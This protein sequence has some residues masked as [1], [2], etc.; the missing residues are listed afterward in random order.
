MNSS[1]NYVRRVHLGST[2]SG[3]VGVGVGG[4]GGGGGSGGGTAAPVGRQISDEEALPRW[5]RNHSGGGGGGGGNCGGGG[6]AA[7]QDPPEV[8]AFKRHSKHSN[9]FLNDAITLFKDGQRV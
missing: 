7:T 1:S 9:K 6:G 5:L 8:A 3:G 4:G 2:G